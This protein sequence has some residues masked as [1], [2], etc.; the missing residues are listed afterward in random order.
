[1][2]KHPL[3][4]SERQQPKNF[5][6]ERKISE[7]VKSATTH[8]LKNSSSS[9]SS[10]FVSTSGRLTTGVNSTLGLSATCSSCCNSQHTKQHRTERPVKKIRRHS[11]RIGHCRK[12]TLQLR[13]E[14]K[15]RKSSLPRHT[16][17][18]YRRSKASRKTAG[19]LSLQTRQHHEASSEIVAM[20]NAAHARIPTSRT[21]IPIQT[22]STL[23]C[24]GGRCLA[25]SARRTIPGS[26]P[27]KISPRLAQLH[28]SHSSGKSNM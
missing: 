17:H 7:D 24:R 19:K 2:K 18:A 5:E 14:R 28:R 10:V 8:I 3:P 9:S 23:Y 11:M 1:M 27:K 25:H 20:T 6:Q 4:K 26:S 12:K 22:Y 16:S 15:R 21:K 13:M